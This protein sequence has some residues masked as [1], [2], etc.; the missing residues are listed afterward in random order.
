[1]LNI[2]YLTIAFL[3]FHVVVS[4]KTVILTGA[5]R[6]VGLATVKLLAQ[7]NQYNIIAA[8]R[9]ESLAAK[10]FSKIKGRENILIQK[11]D[12]A[13]LNSVKSFCDDIKKA[14]IPI[15]VL[16][17]NAGVQFSGSGNVPTRTAQGILTSV[18]SFNMNTCDT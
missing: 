5:N 12:L 7:S 15:D 11:L 18:H 6:G 1:M 17:C 3:Q 4:K 2:I 13:D 9:S 14:K 10:A 8:C 16:V